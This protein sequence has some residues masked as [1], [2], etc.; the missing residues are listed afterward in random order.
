MMKR[1]KKRTV[2][3]VI[4]TTTDAPLEMLEDKDAIWGA[5]DTGYEGAYNFTIGQVH[6]SVAQPPKEK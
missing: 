1:T 2:M 4:E 3:L 5:L 6:A